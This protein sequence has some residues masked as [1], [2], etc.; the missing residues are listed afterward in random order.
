VKGEK[1]NCGTAYVYIHKVRLQLFL[2]IFLLPLLAQRAEAKVI[3]VGPSENIKSIRQ[4]VAAAVNGDQILVR[5]GTYKEGNLVINK[6]LALSGE[7]MPVLEGD[8]KSEIITVKAD[9]V[10]I[11][12]FQIQNSGMSDLEEI[13]GIKL[14]NVSGAK[15]ENNRLINDPFGIYLAN[16]TD[17]LVKNNQIKG[18]AKT[19][20]SYGNAVHIW[21]SHNITVE[22]NDLSGHRDGIYFEFVK[23]SHI[24]NNTSHNNIRYGLHFMFSDGNSY[25]GNSFIKNGAGVA[26][27]Y[28]NNIAMT[29]NKFENNWGPAAYGLLLKEIRNSRINNNIFSRNTM[30]I[31][32]DGGHDVDTDNNTFINNGYALKLIGNS[33]NN[34]VV[35]NNFI[36]NSFDVTTNSSGEMN[37]NLFRGNYWDKY[38]GYDLNRDKV[39]DVPY[40]PV[41]LFS[42]IIEKIP[43][44]VLLLRSFFVSLLDISEKVIPVFTPKTL[45][46]E[47]PLMVMKK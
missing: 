30:G 8:N 6:K 15:I 27:M 40:R 9:G 14:E 38:T 19:E 4:A 22:N 11:K 23:N 35:G 5:G 17:C 21:K 7:N 26:V 10:T 12:G 1:I 46:D 36:A 20:V 45:I 3:K 2:F 24:K 13:A 43:Y 32:I 25:I 18:F 28:T 29:G 41:S 47:K 44:S 39:G 33:Y 42:V 16:S 37:N 31:Y 34:K